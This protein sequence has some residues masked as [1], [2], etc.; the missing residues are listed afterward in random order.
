MNPASQ[1]FCLGQMLQSS[2]HLCPRVRATGVC[3]FTLKAFKQ[4]EGKASPERKQKP[5]GKHGCPNKAAW[6]PPSLPLPTKPDY[7]P[8]G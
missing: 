6:T 2:T 1:S 5:N 8:R 3:R 4:K 7:K